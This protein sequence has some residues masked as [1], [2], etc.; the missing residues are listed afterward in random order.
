MHEAGKLSLDQSKAFLQAS[1]PIRF[2]GQSTQQVYHWVEQV[3][4]HQQ[5][6][7]QSRGARGLPR[8]YLAKMTGLSRAQVT[9]LIARYRAC[10]RVRPTVYRRHRF[11]Q[12]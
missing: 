3:L 9:R 10:G 2:E 5:Y 6:H 8:L 7:Q 1:H 12:R 4:C 11:A